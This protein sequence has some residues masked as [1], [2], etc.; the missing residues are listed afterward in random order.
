MTRSTAETKALKSRSDRL[1]QSIFVRL[2]RPVAPNCFRR[3]TFHVL[4]SEFGSARL[5]STCL[6][7]RYIAIYWKTRRGGESLHGSLKIHTTTSSLLNVMS[8]KPFRSLQGLK[9]VYTTFNGVSWSSR[10]LKL[11]C[12]CSAAKIQKNARSKQI[13][14]S[15]KL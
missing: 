5:W 11:W 4:N 14:A 2:P 8:S 10:E 15:K 9:F 6:N 12:F 7:G 3:Q 1:Q 13:R